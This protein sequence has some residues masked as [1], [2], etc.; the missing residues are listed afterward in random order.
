MPKPV[1]VGLPD[2]LDLW[3]GTLSDTSTIIGRGRAKFKSLWKR[4]GEASGRLQHA[5]PVGNVGQGQCRPS[6]TTSTFVNPGYCSVAAVAES[7]HGRNADPM[8]YR[9]R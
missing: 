3:N 5:K 2:S 1:P 7:C 4:N 8:C 6:D 9:G